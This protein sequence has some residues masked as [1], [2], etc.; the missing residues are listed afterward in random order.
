MREC[1]SGEKQS[2]D[3]LLYAYSESVDR[4]HEMLRT[5]TNI[6]HESYPSAVIRLED[7]KR[8]TEKTLT[9]LAAWLGV[10]DHPCLRHPTFGGLMYEAP[11]ATPIKAFDTSNLDRKLGVLFSEYDQRVMNLLLYPIAVKYG[12]REA[13]STYLANEIAWYKSRVTEPLDFER[14]IQKELKALGCEQDI[15]GPR[16]HFE[17]IAQRC[18]NLL[19]QFETYPAMAP[20][21]RVV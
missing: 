11:A 14:T 21:L 9:S 16:R 1:L 5:V 17:S 3:A 7:V 20:L 19:E 6:A 18:I 2:A 4:L 15:N 13:S 10:E 8:A 12:Y